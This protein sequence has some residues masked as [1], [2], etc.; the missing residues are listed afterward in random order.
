M[1]VLSAIRSFGLICC[2][3]TFSTI[4]DVDGRIMA[5]DPTAATFIGATIC[6]EEKF[7]NPS[8]FKCI[9]CCQSI[10]P[11]TMKIPNGETNVEARK[12]F[13]EGGD[14]SLDADGRASCC[15]AQPL[16]GFLLFS[17]IHFK[18]SLFN[19]YNQ[20]LKEKVTQMKG[21]L[22]PDCV[23]EAGMLASFQAKLDCFDFCKAPRA[24]Y[25]EAQK[26]CPGF[27]APG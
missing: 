19:Q 27:Q 26:Y 6:T 14:G 10:N 4:N 23:T 7:H 1:V 16:V 13:L 17:N 15:L 2:L 3:I 9:M 8:W 25:S 20:I 22:K 11:F 24:D 18:Q 5:S 21:P 12:D